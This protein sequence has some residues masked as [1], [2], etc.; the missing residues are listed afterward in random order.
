MTNTT[1]RIKKGGNNFEILVD[2]DEALKVRKGEGDIARAV[3]TEAVF[4]N[5]KA[6]DHAARDVLE[7]EFGSDD[8]MV[9]SEKIIKNGE[10][11]LP[12]DYVN[13]KRDNKY[14]QV[15]DFLVRNAVSPEGRPYTP[16]RVMTALK[17]AN[18]DVKNK[19]IEEQI[20]RIID[21]LARVLPLK[22]EIKN[23]KLTI[24]AAHTGKAYGI[25]SEFKKNE[26][27]LAN[28]N[29]EIVVGVPA[30][31]LMDFFDR[32][33]SATAGAVLSEELK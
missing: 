12:T 31:L 26:T 1:A 25:V 22:M 23:V 6:G 5:L 21:D 32:L 15:V 8:L 29:L 11:V 24:P 13:Q 20:K 17:E 3:L 18:I 19:P 7:V 4:T 33:N 27:W 30:G 9:V 2:L 28:G 10:V 14:K 16:D